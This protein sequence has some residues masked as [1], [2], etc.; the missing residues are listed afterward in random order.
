MNSRYI[1]E[2][3]MK[4]L[5]LKSDDVHEG[6]L[7]PAS[8]IITD[9]WTQAQKELQEW[10]YS[11]LEKKWSDFSTLSYE[12]IGER[13][14]ALGYKLDFYPNFRGTEAT[15]YYILEMGR[16]RVAIKFVYSTK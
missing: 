1:D 12:E 13:F 16:D 9:L 4:Q 15:H 8:Q 3:M 7:K 14:K 5:G 2:R 11:H 6:L 10:L